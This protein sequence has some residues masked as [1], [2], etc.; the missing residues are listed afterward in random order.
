MD[1]TPI[2]Q[3]LRRAFPFQARLI[4]TDPDHPDLTAGHWFC[5]ARSAGA[6][7]QVLQGWPHRLVMLPRRLVEEI[8]PF[9]ATPD[10]AATGASA[11]VPAPGTTAADALL[12]QFL[13]TQEVRRP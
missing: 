1:R 13:S 11:P 10:A 4:A 5:F 9:E 12:D 2:Y 7:V 3:R 8:L 6:N